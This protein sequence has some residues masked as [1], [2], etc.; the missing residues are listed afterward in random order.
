MSITI[1]EEES[2]YLPEKD[3]CECCIY[4]AAK[5]SLSGTIVM[6]EMIDPQPERPYFPVYIPASGSPNSA[7]IN[8]I[9]LERLNK[10]V[11]NLSV[12]L[13]DVYKQ[14]HHP[15]G[16]G[17][18]GSD[19]PM[20]VRIEIPYT[21]ALLS[22]M[23]IESIP[24]YEEGGTDYFLFGT[25]W[26]GQWAQEETGTTWIPVPEGKMTAM[27]TR[28]DTAQKLYLTLMIHHGGDMHNGVAYVNI[29]IPLKG[30]CDASD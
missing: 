12:D 13:K 7:A 3:A 27:I 4:D 1:C 23:D 25:G 9:T 19:D 28:D 14:S 18:N 20:S 15:V 6:P 10:A 2:V 5:L 22:F 30:E 8:H 26:C 29:L 24:S 21:S 17:A 16:G 11:A